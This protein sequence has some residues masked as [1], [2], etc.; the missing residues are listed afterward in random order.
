MNYTLTANAGPVRNQRESTS[1]SEPFLTGSE[2]EQVF[3]ISASHRLYLDS[4][5]MPHISIG[6]RRRYLRSAVEQFLRERA[7]EQE[8]R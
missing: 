1:A 2:L 4:L 8:A 3:K 6:K 5:G 7:Q